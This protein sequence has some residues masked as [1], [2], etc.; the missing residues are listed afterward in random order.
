[1]TKT[2]MLA[3]V[4]TLGLAGCGSFSGTSS[5]FWIGSEYLK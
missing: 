2:L 1:M 4:A 3:L 5:P